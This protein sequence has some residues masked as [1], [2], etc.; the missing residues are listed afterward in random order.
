MTDTGRREAYRF[1]LPEDRIAQVPSAHRG[2]SRLLVH[3]RDQNATAH[4]S[5]ADF[6]DQL[7]PGDLLV[8]N[9]TR[10]LSARVELSRTTGGVVRGLLVEQPRDQ[11]FILMLEGRGRLKEGEVLM[12]PA[13]DEVLLVE[14]LGNGRWRVSVEEVE[15]G[16]VLLASGRMP[17]PPYIRRKREADPQDDVD[18]ERYQ[19]VFANV[20][21]AVAA[22][23]A[24]LHFTEEILKKIREVGVEVCFVTLHVGPGTFLPVRHDDLSLHTMHPE[25]YV[26]PESTA[27]SVARTKKNGGR[28]V[29]VGTT[30]TRTLEAAAI[31][32][33]KGLV[34]GGTG[35]TDLFIRPPF[36]F[37][38]VDALLTNFHLPGS[39]LLML[40][41]AFTSRESIL[42][43]YEDAVSEDYLFFSYGDA[44]LI[45]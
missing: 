3:H 44:M 27:R 30:V 28:V 42:Q 2:D 39:T 31:N 34:S 18:R 9:D 41:A 1:E 43:V 23:T 12:T 16:E 10:V 7:K 21:G 33:G 26:I 37:Q 6:P 32:G 17:L 5:F 22:P 35:E 14:N 40:V 15:V 29:A 8:L 4:L 19:T 25:R 11:S 24:G 20:P 38:I 36:E 13:G 45:V